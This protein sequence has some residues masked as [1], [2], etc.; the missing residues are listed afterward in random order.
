MKLAEVKEFDCCRCLGQVVFPAESADGIVNVHPSQ[1]CTCYDY[2]F[3]FNQQNNDWPLFRRP[4][5]F[6]VNL[7]IEIHRCALPLLPRL[8]R[9]HPCVEVRG[10][11][12]SG[13]KFQR[14]YRFKR[15]SRLQEIHSTMCSFELFL[16]SA[17]ERGFGRVD[18][19]AKQRCI[20]QL[21]THTCKRPAVKALGLGRG[22]I[23]VRGVSA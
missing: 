23:P 7:F 11:C 10:P 5:R 15:E 1:G 18:R 8:L 16:S 3:F 22:P 20:D 19:P 12:P 21:R 14:L 6:Q 13:L 17:C 4:T 2:L 9:Q